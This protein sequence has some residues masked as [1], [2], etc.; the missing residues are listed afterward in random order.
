MA[1]KPKKSGNGIRMFS[2][3][4]FDVGYL[5][6]KQFYLEALGG[7]VHVEI[8][9]SKANM[10]KVDMGKVTFSSSKIAMTGL[11]REAINEPLLIKGKE[12]SIN[13]LSIGNPHCVI[14]LPAISKELVEEIGPMI[15]NHELFPKRIN[16][17]LLKVLDR[18]NI[19]IE[20][21]E[22]GAGYTLASGSSS[23]AA[24]SVA[25]KFGLVDE[26]INVHM[27]GGTIKIKNSANGHVYMTGS[28]TS[29]SKG[30]IVDDFGQRRD[31]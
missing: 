24:A 6:S 10:I 21:W 20:I 22:R 26:E 8:L 12:F 5:K 29:V 4:L 16:V 15:E 28:V 2:R 27:P 23:C 18:S 3:Y 13:C 19:Q 11:E 1:V 9:D 25:Y 14:P 31:K 7:K 30:Y 17:Q